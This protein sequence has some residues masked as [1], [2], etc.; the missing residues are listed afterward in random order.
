MLDRERQF[1]RLNESTESTAA[2]ALGST[3]NILANRSALIQTLGG[4][5]AMDAEIGNPLGSGIHSNQGA[6]KWQSY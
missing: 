1:W 2:P 5:L 3:P 4:Y 6:K